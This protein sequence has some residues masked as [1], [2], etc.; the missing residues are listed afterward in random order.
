MVMP[1]SIPKTSSFLHVPRS[2]EL[3]FQDR[4]PPKSQDPL[5]IQRT[6]NSLFSL[7][8]QPIYTIVASYYIYPTTLRSFHPYHNTPG[9]IN[10]AIIASKPYHPSD[11]T[12]A[13]DVV[14]DGPAAA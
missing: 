4:L 7:L 12:E 3:P 10:D 1:R 11:R 5:R 13:S 2:D 14:E 9:K 6:Q 8:Q